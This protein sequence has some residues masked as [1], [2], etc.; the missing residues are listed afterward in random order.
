[1]LWVMLVDLTVA[2]TCAGVGALC[3]F[4]HSIC[5]IGSVS[6][7]YSGGAAPWLGAP[8]LADAVVV[9]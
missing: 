4:W 9:R 5:S 2:L 8:Y 1:M 6:Q 7:R 3:C